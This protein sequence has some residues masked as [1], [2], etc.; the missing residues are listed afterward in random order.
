MPTG[1]YTRS[2]YIRVSTRVKMRQRMIGNKINVGK[3]NNKGKH[4]KLS[5]EAKKNIGNGKIGNKNGKWKGGKPKCLD[6]G[7]QLSGYISKYCN[8]HKNNGEKSRF[9]KGGITSISAQMR[10]SF[11]YQQWRKQ[12]FTRADHIYPFSLF[13]RLQLALENGRT[14]CVECHKKTDTYMWKIRDY[15]KVYYA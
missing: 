8:H 1:V 13:P 2:K 7:K 15:N 11:E 3:Q 6:C 9:W 4:W 14:L 12:V 10:N 5:E